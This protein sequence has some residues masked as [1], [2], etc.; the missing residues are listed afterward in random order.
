M[1]VTTGSGEYGRA[2]AWPAFV[3]AQAV[4]IGR[5]E[6]AIAAYPYPSSYRTWPGPNSNTFVDW[7]LRECHIPVDLAA[8]SIGK[9]YRGLLGFS[10]TSG[11]TGLQMETP[12]VGIKLGATE[13]VEVHMLT[14]AIGIDWWPPALILPVGRLGVDDR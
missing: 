10:T 5:V 8:Q 2:S 7:L 3:T 13:G 14:L 9:D 1:Q 4:L 12:I 11:G 6:A